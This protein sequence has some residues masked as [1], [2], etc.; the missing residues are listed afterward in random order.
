MYP[1]SAKILGIEG[2]VV[3]EALIELDGS[4]SKVEVARSVHPLLDEAAVSAMKRA[5]FSPAM[6]NGEPVKV[7]Y[8][9][10]FV[11]KLRDADD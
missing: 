9:Q 6:A 1:D 11:F 10:G 5:K 7:W 3:V 4:V 2:R 8:S